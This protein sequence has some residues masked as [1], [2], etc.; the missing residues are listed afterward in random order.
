MRAEVST[1]DGNVT[2][3]GPI[4]YNFLSAGESGEKTTSLLFTY[5]NQRGGNGCQLVH[6]LPSERRNGRDRRHARSGC[7]QTVWKDFCPPFLE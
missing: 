7:L 1:A 6:F 5:W 3:V 4:V 2:P